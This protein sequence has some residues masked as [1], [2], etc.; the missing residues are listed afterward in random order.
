[1]YKLEYLPVA[2]N[3]MVETVQYISQ[4]LKNPAAAEHLAVEMIEAAENVLAFPYALPAYQPLRPLKHEYRKIIVKNFLMFYWVDEE[5]RIVTIAR[6]IYT[7]RNV[8]QL[9]E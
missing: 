1:M 9:L 5:K 8:V 3:D 4:K 6:V 7:K 2:Q